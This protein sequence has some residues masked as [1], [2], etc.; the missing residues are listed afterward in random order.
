MRAQ[1]PK[2]ANIDF[3]GVGDRERECDFAVRAVKEMN[4]IFAD[5]GTIHIGIDL[6]SRELRYQ[7]FWEE[8]VEIG[9][10]PAEGEGPVAIAVDIEAAF[11]YFE[12]DVCLGLLGGLLPSADDIGARGEDPVDNLGR[13]V[14]GR[15]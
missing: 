2:L 12:G 9:S 15:L 6:A 5:G 8:V 14:F 11:E 1:D 4:T 3:A 13:V 10:R 7:I